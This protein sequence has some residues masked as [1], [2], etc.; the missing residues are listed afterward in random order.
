MKKNELAIAKRLYKNSPDSTKN[1]LIKLH[2]TLLDC[3]GYAMVSRYSIFFTKDII[4]YANSGFTICF[5]ESTT[6]SF[7]KIFEKFE[8]FIPKDFTPIDVDDV[9]L[10]K[11]ENKGA[12]P[13]KGYAINDSTAINPVFLLDAMSWVKKK[14]LSIAEDPNFPNGK[15]IFF[16]NEDIGRLAIVLPVR[17]INNNSNTSD[18]KNG[19]AKSEASSESEAKLPKKYFESCSTAEELKAEYKKLAKLL[20]PDNNTESDTTE[21]FKSMQS[22]FSELWESL[23]TKHKNANGV[24]YEKATEET[25]G[26]FIDL[27]NQL[28]KLNGCEVEMC[29]SW[30]WVSGNTKEHKETLKELK[31]RFSGNKKAWYY[32]NG[33]YYRRNNQSF[34]MNDIRNMWTSKKFVPNDES[35]PNKVHQLASK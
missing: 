22:Q 35:T 25:A 23:K 21:E 28:L 12:N 8:N 2:S 10:F 16:F 11:K 17:T 4:D 1:Q 6:S 3:D 32:H 15:A 5:D 27:V 34:S 9:K 29:G 33:N 18:S 20:H 30:I 19:S 14:E 24:I 26:E 31:F 7:N 13:P